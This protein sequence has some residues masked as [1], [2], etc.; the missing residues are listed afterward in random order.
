MDYRLKRNQIF[1]KKLPVP[2]EIQE[3]VY[4]KTLKMEDYIKYDLVDKVPIEHIYWQD[5]A[6]VE[7]FSAEKLKQLDF[8]MYNKNT[9]RYSSILLMI[10][11]DVSDLNNAFYKQIM[12]CSTKGVDYDSGPYVPILGPEDVTPTLLE[13]MHEYFVEDVDIIP[14]LKDKFYNG[15]LTLFDLVN[16]WDIFKNKNV[17]GKLEYYSRD[18]NLSQL[19]KMMDEYP[20]IASIIHYS[21]TFKSLIEQLYGDGSSKEQRE[22]I[23]KNFCVEV[24]S[25]KDIEKTQEVHNIVFSYV[26][27]DKY[28]QGQMDYLR[29]HKHE[30]WEDYSYNYE[31]FAK[32]L[33]GM[34]VREV[35]EA[36]FTMDVLL[37]D[38]VLDFVRIYGIKNI[39]EF[40]QECGN[41]F[42][43][44][45]FE[46]LRLMQPM[47]MHYA[48]NNH[49]PETT[50]FTRSWEDYDRPYTKEE[51]YEAI[52][53]M[54]IGGPTDWDYK[55]RG[56]DYRYITGLFRELNSDLFVS[57]KL[58]EDIQL[59]FYTKQLTPQ[60]IIDNQDIIP[61]LK[62]KKLSSCFKYLNI[63]TINEENS[64]GEYNNIYEYLENKFGFDKT[65]EFIVNYGLMAE[66]VF[67]NYDRYPKMNYIEDFKVNEDISYESLIEKMIDKGR[68]LVIKTKIKYN[69]ITLAPLRE[70]YPGLFISE[71]APKELQ[72]LFYNRELK[73]DIIENHPEYIQYIQNIDLELL[74]KY[75]EVD[76]ERKNENGIYKTRDNLMNI[77]KDVF[78]EQSFGVML[79][80][81]KYL[82]QIYDNNKLNGLK[83]SADFSGDDLLDALDDCLFDGISS[84]FIEHSDKF[85]THF[86]NNYPRLFLPENTPQD[87][88]DKY[89][90]KKFVVNDF[91]DNNDLLRYFVETDIIY[92]LGPSF[93]TMCGLFDNETFLQIIKLCGEEIKNETALFQFVKDK[94]NGYVTIEKFSELVYEFV[95]AGNN[96]LKFIFILDRLGYDNEE[97]RGMTEKIRKLIDYRPET[98]FNNPALSL[99]LLSDEI[100]KKLGYDFI[101]A[102]LEYNSGA[103]NIVIRNIKDPIFEEWIHYIENLPI[104]NKK[105][106]HFA[107]LSYPYSQ[108]LVEELVTSSVILNE[109]QLQ[110]LY[111]ILV[112]RNKYEVYDI[113]TLTDY[114]V[115][116]SLALENKIKDG[117]SI[118]SVK[119][120]ILEVL[121]NVELSHA[122]S[123]FKVYG[124][125]SK[126]FI[127]NLLDEGVLDINDKAAIEIVREIMNENDINKLRDTFE[128]SI[129]RGNI[130]SLVE[131]EQKL[132]LYF[133]KSFK[134][135]L[136]QAD[137]VEKLGIKYS[138]IDGLQDI[139]LLDVNGREITNEDKIQVVELEGIDFKLLIHKIHNYDPK[140]ASLATRIINDPSLWNKLEGASTL[141]TSMIS[142]THMSCVG[143]GSSSAVYYGFN[144][145]SSSSLWLMGRSDIYVEHGGRKL[146]PTSHRNEF[147]IPDILQLVSTSY[148]EV[149]LD[150]KSSEHLD[151]DRRIQPTC[152]ICFDGNI[153]DDSKRAAQYF[154]IPIYMIHR[155]KYREHNQSLTE[156]YNNGTIDSMTTVDVRQILCSKDGNL[157]DRYQLLLNLCDKA[158]DE[159]F[160]TSDDYVELLKEGRRIITHFSTH[161]SI[162]GID[163]TEISIRIERV[164]GMGEESYESG[165]TI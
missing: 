130:I 80:Y 104:Y 81:G 74:Y 91:I 57:D 113:D 163:L 141:S 84:G 54:I 66:I 65:M 110:N 106:L 33:D 118:N 107:I 79:L 151:F 48:G 37:D 23:I 30:G 42:S 115:H 17:T 142:S 164:R 116:R 126:S 52:R 95:R 105:L 51:F 109:N 143:H 22:E 148:N 92:C 11:P 121:F 90:N 12:E 128:N 27:P 108:E 158:L 1:K 162:S 41:F 78:G 62:G 134:D 6:V 154:D 146:E 7:R 124:L 10:S 67:G 46:M 63:T 96:S 8:E 152:I 72:D 94:S 133:G 119:D 5:R 2:K 25:D 59:A 101:S 112:Q 97:L 19:R 89:Y 15:N 149:A 71:N 31:E 125:N 131:L 60:I 147:M 70:K 58:P 135:S 29:F 137:G 77:I 64:Y 156:M 18:I 144:D 122:E 117:K 61:E 136:F 40:D 16:N 132:K 76:V 24:L 45:N 120:G 150:R 26:E 49:N 139:K 123:I 43:R 75:M 35:I 38:A 138:E 87:I 129:K 100:V 4:S 161:N 44:N 140:F 34:T 32:G 160:I 88:K 165:K 13:K 159:N 114:D 83:I 20:D 86:K 82:E 56:T 85:P 39:V 145:I 155:Q 157:T 53:R 36:G 102:I 50:Y 55:G 111:E 73:L 14:E 21:S 99:D 93:K 47:Y 28:L 9:S 103:H 127:D 153:N 3:Q 68:E 98:D 69:P